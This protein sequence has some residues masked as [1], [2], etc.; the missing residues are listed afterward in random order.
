MQP[1][2]PSP[3]IPLAPS[4]PGGRGPMISVGGLPYPCIC[5]IYKEVRKYDFIVVFR[6]DL[7]HKI[8]DLLIIFQVSVRVTWIIKHC[9]DL[10]H[11]S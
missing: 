6:T 2:S 10:L 4:S 3:G 1:S 11:T 7:A 8:D 5:K 9:K